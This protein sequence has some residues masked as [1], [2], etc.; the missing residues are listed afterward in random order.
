MHSILWYLYGISAFLMQNDI[1]SLNYSKKWLAKSIQVIAGENFS[2]S[3]VTEL[4]LVRAPD[5][6]Y[7]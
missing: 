6:Q 2:L 1:V 5:T 7:V 3:F 4:K